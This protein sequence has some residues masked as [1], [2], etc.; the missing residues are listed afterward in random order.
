MRGC[1]PDA[2]ALVVHVENAGDSMVPLEA[3][4]RVHDGK[5]ILAA[6]RLD[7]RLRRA[8]AHAHDREEPGAYPL[9]KLQRRR[10]LADQTGRQ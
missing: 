5:V 7:D 9:S 6:E 3:V 2:D 10:P 1:V 8:I 4:R